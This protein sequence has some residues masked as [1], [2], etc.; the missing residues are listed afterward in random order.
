VLFNFLP[1]AAEKLHYLWRRQRLES[2]VGLLADELDLLGFYLQTGFNVGDLEAR[3][4]RLVLTGMSASI[5]SYYER[6]RIGFRPRKPRLLRSIWWD[7]VLSR[8]GTHRPPR[9]LE[10]SVKLLHVSP[11]DQ[12]R[13]LRRFRRLAARVASNPAFSMIKSNAEIFLSGPPQRR[14][15]F[16]FLAYREKELPSRNIWMNNA[17]AQAL[18]QF[19]V[20]SAVV[21]AICV[22][23]DDLPYGALSVFSIYPEMPMLSDS[24]PH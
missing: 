18:T 2:S 3:P 15:A 24:A 6:L 9:W 20:Q 1:T 14:D 7:A 17:G 12:R 5:D 4:T 22:D 19:G 16:V 10:L 13:T 21:I 11:G 23:R 8:L